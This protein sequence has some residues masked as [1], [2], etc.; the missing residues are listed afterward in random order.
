[1]KIT[2]QKKGRIINPFYINSFDFYQIKYDDELFKNIS[3]IGYLG[4]N[5]IQART[6]TPEIG[7]I[8]KATYGMCRRFGEESYDKDRTTEKEVR[9]KVGIQQLEIFANGYKIHD[10]QILK[11]VF[12]LK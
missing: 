10:G 9:L 6:L 3:G 2:E 1:M 11:T 8:I 7:G 5:G 12:F 4:E